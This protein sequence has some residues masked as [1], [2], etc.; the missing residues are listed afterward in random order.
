MIGL[1]TSYTQLFHHSATHDFD[2]LSQPATR[3]LLLVRG[4]AAPQIP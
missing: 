3:N 2:L 4:Y 1:A